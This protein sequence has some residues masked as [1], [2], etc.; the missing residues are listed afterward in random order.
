[1]VQLSLL[2]GEG[3]SGADFSDCRL[4]RYALWRRWNPNQRQLVVIGLNPSTADETM[5]DPTVERCKRRAVALG[6]GGLVMLNL[7]ALRSTHPGKLYDHPSPVQA[8]K[9]NDNDDALI[10]YTFGG[11]VVCAWGN[12]GELGNRG[13]NV[14]LFLRRLGHTL[15]AFSINKSGHPAHPL[16][17]PY[18]AVP[19]V[20]HAAPNENTAI[21]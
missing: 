8:P 4:Y 19:E 13:W 18:S 7:F 3:G 10:A 9:T 14:A 21:D 2:K 12:H 15:H 17:L 16:Y 11:L 20:W 1:M 6:C 5:N